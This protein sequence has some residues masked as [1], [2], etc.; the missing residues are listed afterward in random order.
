MQ[1]DI[2]LRALSKTFDDKRVLSKLEMTVPGDKITCLMGASGAGKTT[3]LRILL[4]LERADSG[5]ICGLPPRVLC[6]F[7]EDRLAED[8]SVISNIR[9]GAPH[10]SAS[11]IETHLS[12]LLL[13]GE[14]K[15]PV[16]LLSGGMKRRVALCRAVCAPSDL[17]LLDEPFKG[18]DEQAARA[19]AD[20]LIRHRMGRTVLVVTHEREDAIRLGAEI[21][22]LP[23]EREEQPQTR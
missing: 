4:G 5:E 7:Q 20:Y 18:L 10:M 16:R 15:R 3:L 23:D 17:L 12:E 19:A 11:E 14:G 13:A 21:L 22:Y 2:V 6:L 9:L 1:K 8:F